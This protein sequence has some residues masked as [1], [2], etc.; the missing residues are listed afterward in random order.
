MH[1]TG[2]LPLLLCLLISSGLQAQVRINEF[3]ASNDS[4]PDHP[5]G[6]MAD[7]HD[8]S[9][10]IELY[11]EA[12]S[13]VDL[14]D[15]SL[16]DD[17]DRPQRWRFPRGTS[18]AAGG[19]LVVFASGKDRRRDPA[20]L[21]TDFKLAADGEHLLLTR[22][23][24]STADR[25]GTHCYPEQVPD[26]SYGR[27]AGGAWVYF[28]DES[29]A[30]PSRGSANSGRH[31]DGPTIQIVE[32]PSGLIATTDQ[33]IIRA[34]ITGADSVRLIAQSGFGS[35]QSLGMRD[36]GT[37]VD[38]QAGD[39]IYSARITGAVDAGAGGMLRWRIEA[40]NSSGQSRAPTW[41]PAMDNS[42]RMYGALVQDEAPD[43]SLL[44]CHLFIAEPA[45]ADKR[46]GTRASLAAHG[47][48]FDNVFIRKRGG[49]SAPGSRKIE[50]NNIHKFPLI[51]DAPRVDEIN[52]NTAGKDVSHMR[53]ILSWEVI[54]TAGVPACAAVP[55]HVFE[56]GS[57]VAVRIAIEQ[58]DPDF[59]RRH[60]LPDSGALYKMTQERNGTPREID[61][62]SVEKKTRLWD[63]P[64]GDAK[65][66]L[67]AFVAAIQPVGDSAGLAALERTLFEQ[68]DLPAVV[69]YMA[70]MCLIGETDH[71][72]KNHYF[73]RDSE[74]AGTWR[75][76]AW[77]KDLPFGL[78]YPDWD[79][80]DNWNPN[81]DHPVFQHPFYA[82]EDHKKT[83]GKWNYLIHAITQNPRTRNM[84]LRRLRSL[85]DR[86]LTEDTSGNSALD[87]RIDELEALLTT[88]LSGGA[89]SDL[90]KAAAALHQENPNSEDDGDGLGYLG[91]RRRFLYEVHAQ[92]G[93]TPASSDFA[94]IPA[95]Q[96]A[97]PGIR[98]DA[99]LVTPSTGQA[100]E[101]LVLANDEAAAVDIS[102]WR[103]S[104]D[105]R[106]RF[107]PGTVIPSGERLY[108]SP[109]VRTFLTTHA[110]IEDGTP[111]FV[112]GTYR[113]QLD[114]RGG[115]VSLYDTA[116]R[117]VDEH[118]HAAAPTVAQQAIRITEIHYHPIDGEQYE[119]IELHN[120]GTQNVDLSGARLEDAVDFTV[121]DG[122][123]LAPGAYALV[124]A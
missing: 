58:P 45:D 103:L 71:P 104:G 56:N 91:E 25:V 122:T 83:D 73:Y 100:A 59:L 96:A 57:F 5:A 12:S 2:L 14:S 93:S 79:K 68:V 61:D 113:G 106:H 49:F 76:L 18:I 4:M 1:H 118:T 86:I 121:P 15:W 29:N 80:P 32:Q 92:D 23:D 115:T 39:G 43:T 21:H 13:A 33:P 105:I 11:N 97:D 88:S 17:P 94:G 48:F 95:S 52:L 27:D 99:V 85:M 108:C 111:P 9:D 16:S 34:R 6:S 75:I 112:Q 8:T 31:S 54:G 20:D 51:A 109:D 114:A 24:G 119:F 47:E 74:G 22:A 123:N 37:G 50:F 89:A 41:F 55:M 30:H 98:I 116:E 82:D 120:I 70:A 78:Y 107:A 60:D 110:D 65:A 77:D 84:Y 3:M 44:A 67:R 42:P 63:A 81:G 28:V 102:G 38:L 87:R 117:L 101:Y 69:S 35:E 124:V 26:V 7:A 36:N 72:H 66:D 90:R 62:A 19:H 46:S 40:E 53:R 64:S 10:W